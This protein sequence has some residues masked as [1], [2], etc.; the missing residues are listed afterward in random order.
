[1]LR[2]FSRKHRCENLRSESEFMF[3]GQGENLKF[4]IRTK[5][6]IKLGFL[7]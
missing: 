1:M 4:G 5:Q 6:G 7:C 2:I 3:F